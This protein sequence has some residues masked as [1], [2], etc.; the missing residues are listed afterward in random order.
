MGLRCAPADLLI[1]LMCHLHVSACGL[2]IE[3]LTAG[4]IITK[5]LG[6]QLGWSS[7]PSENRVHIFQD[8]IG[9][10][11]NDTHI[12]SVYLTFEWKI[13]IIE[14]KSYQNLVTLKNCKSC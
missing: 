3:T 4:E 1:L 14:V 6:G 11:E 5:R 7:K 13:I 12:M 8:W 10:R 9:P 2:N